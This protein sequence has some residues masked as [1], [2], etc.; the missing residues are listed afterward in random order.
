MKKPK[1]H[2][3]AALW[4]AAFI[5]IMGVGYFLKDSGARIRDARCASA[6]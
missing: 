1:K 6:T 3:E 5:A 2:I 4:L